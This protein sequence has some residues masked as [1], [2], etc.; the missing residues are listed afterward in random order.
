[1][2]RRASHGFVVVLGDP[3][4]YGRFGFKPAREWALRDEYGG[5]DAFQ[6]LELQPGTIPTGGGTV[7]YAPQF[8]MVTE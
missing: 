6:A 4:Y 3:W 5:G 8:A 7:V 2:C 1:M